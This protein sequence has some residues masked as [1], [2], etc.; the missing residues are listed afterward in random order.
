MLHLQKNNFNKSI[1][2]EDIYPSYISK[3]RD[4]DMLYR[5]QNKFRGIPET[6]I[7]DHFEGNKTIGFLTRPLDNSERKHKTRE[8]LLR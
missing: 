5:L 3:D 7:I 4:H 2:I 6:V 1:I 8:Q